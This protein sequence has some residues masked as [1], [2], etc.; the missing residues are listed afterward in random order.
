MSPNTSSQN[1]VRLAVI[2]GST[3]KDRIA[4]V[5]SDWFTAR[6]RERADFD[7]DVIDL[8]D[9]DLPHILESPDENGVH[10]SQ[11]VRDFAQR[12]DRADVFAVI[13]PEYNRGY[14]ASLKQAIDSVYTEF[15]AKP[16]GFISYSGGA[17]GGV[18][19]VEQLRTVFAELHT[20]TLRDGV[21]LP[22]VYEAFD[23][24]GQPRDAEAVNGAAKQ[25][26]D[27]MLWWA[28]AMRAAR[29]KSPYT[30]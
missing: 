20:V 5:V 1:S 30:A 16:V 23:E 8:A 2:V 15:H 4:P 26:L 21:I 6:A 14:P 28:D 10:P 24:E 25:L 19:A 7:V 18:R 27:Q 17:T 22:S 12:V 11:A 9:A 29:A 13:T 3:R